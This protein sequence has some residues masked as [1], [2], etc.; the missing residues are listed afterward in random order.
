[1]L[2]IDANLSWLLVKDLGDMAALE[3]M[4]FFDQPNVPDTLKQKI[5]LKQVLLHV[6]NEAIFDEKAWMNQLYPC[7]K[8]S[9]QSDYFCSYVTTPLMPTTLK[10]SNI[11]SYQDYLQQP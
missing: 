2:D 7:T 9:G 6:F 11:K 5:L 8:I 3:D 10:I 1:M 4:Y